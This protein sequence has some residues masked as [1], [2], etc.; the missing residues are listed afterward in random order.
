VER[1]SDLL[2]YDLSEL[3]IGRKRAAK[4]FTAV[5]DRANLQLK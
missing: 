5:S 4:D 2:D 1:I 3:L